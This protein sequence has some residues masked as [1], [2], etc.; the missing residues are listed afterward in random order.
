MNQGLTLD[1]VKD[2]SL[3]GFRLKRLE[4]LNWGTFDQKVWSFDIDGKN[5]L[6][7]GDI[8]SGKS[9]LVDAVTTLLV[10]AHRVAYNKAAGA[11][12]KERDLRSYVLGFYKS[13]QSESVGTA[14][15]VALRKHG[16][17]SVILGEFY[18]EG[19]D[20]TV[21]LA[22]V[23]WFRQPQGQP[24]RFYAVADEART[25]QEHFG[26]FGTE[27]A[28]LRKRLKKQQVNLFDAFPAYGA[29]F[30]RRFGIE[31]E[32]ALELFHQTV[33]MKSIGNLTE[34]VRG[35]MLEAFD[36]QSRID[37]LI[38]HF[39]D[40]DRAHKAV[41]TAKKQMGLLTPLVEKC[42][43][44]AVLDRE[45]LAWE[46]ARQA[47]RA[48]MG[49]IK[50]DLL[51]GRMVKLDG[52]L[53]RLQFQV[54]E[55]NEKVKSEQQQE[56]ELERAIADQ[57]G[58]RIAVLEQKID[59][60]E[61]EKTRCLQRAQR[62]DEIIAH[63]ELPAVKDVEAFLQQRDSCLALLQSL[64]DEEAQTQNDMNELGVD[65]A[66]GKREYDSLQLELKGLKSRKSNIHE[67]QIKIRQRLCADLGLAEEAMP[68]AGELIQV[69]EDERDWQGAAER[70]LHG[71]ALSM[72]V[73][74]AYYSKVMAW[75]N[76]HHLQGRLVFYRVRER[77]SE[78]G[79]QHS[80]QHAT[81]L[82]HKLEVKPDSAFYTWLQQELA[83]RFDYACCQDLESFRRETRAI[84]MAGQIKAKGGRHE[85]DDRHRIDDKRRFVLGWSNAEKIAA[86]EVEADRQQQVLVALG[87]R[88]AGLQKAL[89]SKQLRLSL[90]NQL[91]AY[92]D[93]Q[94]VNWRPL[95]VEVEQLSAEKSALEAAS[96]QLRL[97]AEQRDK[98][99][100]QLEKDEALLL[101]RRDEC[102][103]TD[104]KRTDAQS[105]H[106]NLQTLL[107]EEGEAWQAYQAVLK[108]LADA[109]LGKDA[110]Q[111]V[112]FCES[113]EQAL[114]GE[115]NKRMQSLDG[116]LSRLYAHIIQEMAHF[117]EMYPLETQEVDA[118]LRAAHEYEKMLESLHA[119]GL[120]NF[121]ARFK[122]MLNENTI[123]EIANFQSQ[124][125]RERE[126]IK[127]RIE[128][129]NASLTH[130]DY[131][132]GRYIT[133][134]AQPAAD[135][136]IQTF[137]QDLKACTEGSVTG[138]ED[139]QYSE[140]KFL[141][142]QKIIARFRGREGEADA[143]LRWQRKVSD[144]RNWFRFAASE[145][146]R[147]DDEEYEHYADSGG[148]SGGQK[149]KLAYT[150]LAASLAYQFGLEW[151][152][153]RS[154]SFR[155]VVIDEAFG[156]GSDESAE[157]GLKLFAQL[158]LQLLIVTPLQKI[159]IIEPHVQH[160]GYVSNEGGTSSK[161][162]NLSIETYREEK[163]QRE[164]VV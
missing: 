35:H 87:D 76:E 118:N 72:L 34:F 84:T 99:L 75:V 38:A 20:Q 50:S 43:Q 81:S 137:Q 69:R 73:A 159:H 85:K 145:R 83:K 92:P 66:A 98:V 140:K 154:R 25:I 40:L 12:A 49:N 121:E 160:V 41:L 132:E 116:K 148:K 51:A 4:V 11:T 71:F 59:E 19:Y 31:N 6:L 30:R 156:R 123:R 14:K 74:D 139:E 26:G 110:P 142:V 109:V 107:L 5:V 155:F 122:E 36:V 136:E 78:H 68:F 86:L 42:Q 64:A 151:N 18:N 124:L 44:H 9:T 128:R 126:T 28:A 16:S 112:A 94:D 131:V 115:L 113:Q 162:R 53:E 57:G 88:I 21:T 79:Q 27:M 163:R 96:D 158:N 135:A 3:T 80:P 114:R 152:A 8:G 157:Y 153:V 32:Q 106:A 67:H 102:S 95:A 60:K 65:L 120:P 119:D 134:L 93:F 1:F 10:P 39:D 101:K 141:Q 105:M 77:L 15:P 138:S 149:E 62:Y 164:T 91:K 100:S 111:Q 56:R 55:L 104:Q 127:E 103:K 45:K 147:E 146:W 82:A 52:E 133:L 23:F 13:E 7:T 125:L 22:Q 108:E 2:D 37:A 17:Y 90:L 89:K 46:Q 58:D 117:K 33:S 130:I 63:L 29:F 48:Y 144:V 143:D 61:Q 54:S 129:I 70:L 24:E 150:I 47:L 97:L 161:L